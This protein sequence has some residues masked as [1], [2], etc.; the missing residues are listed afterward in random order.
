MLRR[1]SC[2][3]L[4]FLSACASLPDGDQRASLLAMPSLQSLN[5]TSDNTQPVWPKS[6]WWQ[7]FGNQEL[8]RLMAA[9]L[10]D[11]PGLQAAQ[12]RV[13]EQ[14]ALAD[15]QAAEMLPTL[16]GNAELHYRR[17]SA[18][19]FYGP[20]GGKTFTGAY[21]DPAVF[22]YHLDLWGKDRAALEA[23]LGLQQARQSEAA[24]VQLLLSS[25]I[26]RDYLRL[27]AN[28]ED[29]EL[30]ERFTETAQALLNLQVLRQRN[31]LIAAD[32]LHSGD[33]LLQA[34]RQQQSALRGQQSLWRNRLAA[35]AGQGP[36][37]GATI[38]CADLHI[39]QALPEP[40]NLALSLLAHRP[41]LQA[42][43]QRV[44]AAQQQIRI[45]QSRFYPDVNLVGFAGLRSLS[46][47]DLF[48]SHGASLAYGLGPTVSLPIFEGGRLQANLQHQQAAY[49]QA[50]ALY[51]Q[52]LL[53]AVQQV[54]DSVADWQQSAERD[55]AQRSAIDAAQ[56]QYRLAA[57]RRQAGIAVRDAELQAQQQL[58]RQQL[59]GSAM[60]TERNLAAIAIIEALGGGFR[61]PGTE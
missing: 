4:L 52:T 11:N 18:S 26:A 58:L 16:Y 57:Q 42:A 15:Y 59:S 31:G 22:R 32:A 47:N 48:L 24:M 49:D 14:Q 54:A 13:A 5:S 8:S 33:Q 2:L 41:D 35:L 45:A 30:A 53:N 9:A 1:Y 21:L 56:A 19:D 17:F 23:A 46:L 43:L 27:C 50:V 38:Q 3:S 25:A 6:Q 7:A 51:N 36:D 60:R 39:N 20:N 28:A 61:Q 40:R 12:A 34:A 55:N 44:Q 37:W 29:L 10:Q